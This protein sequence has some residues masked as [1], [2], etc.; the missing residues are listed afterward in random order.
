[1][2]RLQAYSWFR[3]SAL[4]IQSRNKGKAKHDDG[5]HIQNDQHDMLSVDHAQVR[6]RPRHEWGAE[7]KSPHCDIFVVSVAGLLPHSYRQVALHLI[8]LIVH[9]TMPSSAAMVFCVLVSRM[10][11][12]TCSWVG[13]AAPFRSPH[14]AYSSS[15]SFAQPAACT[16]PTRF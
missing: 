3:V 1:M 6:A 7:T 9:W 15:R 8:S 11:A 13:R 16:R 4:A 12:R 5:C 10:I 14:R 2:M